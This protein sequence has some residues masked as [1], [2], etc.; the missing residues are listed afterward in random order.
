M[1]FGIFINDILTI[2][3]P[4]CATAPREMALCDGWIKGAC[5]A[6]AQRLAERLDDGLGQVLKDG[7]LTGFDFD[8]ERP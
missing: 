2:Y 8:G 1:F 6:L 5:S 4:A 3:E 7:A